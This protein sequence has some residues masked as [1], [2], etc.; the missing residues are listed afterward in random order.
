MR[1]RTLLTVTALAAV[2]GAVWAGS[3]SLVEV[4]GPSMLPALWPGDRLLT[5][6]PRRS[7]IVP[8]RLVVVEDPAEPGHL[9]VKR[10]HRA[11]GGQVDVRGD[12]AGASTDSTT[13][14]P[15]PLA[16]VRRVVL[17]RWPDLRTRLHRAGPTTG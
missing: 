17:R 7:A 1:T 10:V 4:Q 16:N 12:H 15:V 5:V 8:G 2:Y 9:V 11:G 13:W 6:P 14:G 3:R